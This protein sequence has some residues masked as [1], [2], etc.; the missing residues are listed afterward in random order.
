M[1]S[2]FQ[3]RRFLQRTAKGET[4]FEKTIERSGE[5]RAR[6]G[7]KRGQVCAIK[8]HFTGRRTACRQSNLRLAAQA[9]LQKLTCQGGIKIWPCVLVLTD[10]LPYGTLFSA[11]SRNQ[12]S[13]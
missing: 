7:V 12:M 10:K 9:A 11:I 6:H 1:E 5:S 8:H 2:S 3:S 13:H 4:A